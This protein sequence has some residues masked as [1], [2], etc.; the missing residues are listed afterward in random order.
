MIDAARGGFSALLI[1]VSGFVSAAKRLSATGCVA[2][3]A[4]LC[5]VPAAVHAEDPPLSQYRTTVLMRSLSNPTQMAFLPDGRIYVTRKNGEVL[6]YNPATLQ[7]TTVATLSVG[8]AREDGLHSIVLD[9]AFPSTP[10]VYLLFSNATRDSI[11]VARFQADSATGTLISASR[12]SLLSVP[13]T[14]NSSPAEHND[15][16]LAFG[17]DGNLYIGLPDNTQNIF[18][19]NGAGYSPRDP[20]RPLYDAQRSAA[21]TNDLKGKILRIRPEANGTYSIPA[22]NLFPPGM[23]NTRPEIYVMGLRHPFRLTIDPVTG[24]LFWGE[25]GPNATSDNPVR[26]PR[27]YEEVN[28]AKTPGNYGWP[29]CAANNRCYASN[30][31]YQTNTGGAAYNPE[32]LQNTSVNNTGIVDLPPARPALVWYAYSNPDTSAFPAFGSGGSNTGMLGP[33]Y[34]YDNNATS[35]TRM[36]SAFHRHLFMV[37]WSRSRIVVGK[38]DTAGQISDVRPFWIT[39]DSTSNSPID[40]KIGPDGALYFLNWVGTGYTNNSGNGTLTRLEYT[41]PQIPIALNPGIARGRG[42]TGD[43]LFAAEAG[44]LVTLPEG[45]LGADVYSLR[46]E[47]LWHFHRASASESGHFAVPE[48]VRGV[49]RIRVRYR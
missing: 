23:P 33:F 14:I 30:F 1:Q 27:G 44:R 35:A 48:T 24:W 9:P 16:C 34:R 20:S 10:W 32:A 42:V 7:T 46:G 19:G 2:A 17:P 40:V 43:F 15:G 39:R 38:V 25:P 21:N 12:Q 47:R 29:Y 37:E 5:A 8:N 36:P 45:A 28:L 31:N 22:G 18:S 13:Y 26:G 49:V 6:L 3:V 11:V 41:G 4:L